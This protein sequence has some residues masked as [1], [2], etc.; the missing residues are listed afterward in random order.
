[1]KN[2]GGPAFPIGIRVNDLSADTG[3][4]LRYWFAGKS[5]QGMLANQQS[6][7]EG[8]WIDDDGKIQPNDEI[9]EALKF[10]AKVAYMIAD[11]MIEEGKND[12]P[13]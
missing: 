6:S 12:S 1:M 7:F 3:I 13:N 11:I 10:S 5:M 9:K 2:D 8:I 4:P